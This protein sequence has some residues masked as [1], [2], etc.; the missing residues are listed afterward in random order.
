M[1]LSPKAEGIIYSE[2]FPGL[3]LNKLALL[4]RNVARALEFVLRRDIN[5]V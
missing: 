2:V 3:L 5:I 4:A 1:Q